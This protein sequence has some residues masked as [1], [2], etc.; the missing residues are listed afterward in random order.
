[1]GYRPSRTGRSYFNNPGG[2][3]QGLL[4]AIQS[5]GSVCAL[6]IAPNL[7][8][9]IG[10]KCSI[11]I[12]SLIVALGAGLQFGATDTG[13]FIAGRFFIG[14]GSGINGIASPLLI[15]ELAHPSQRGKITAVYNTFYYFRSTIAAWQVLSRCLRTCA[16]KCLQ[17][18]LW[19]SAN[20]QQ[21]VMEIAQPAASRAQRYTAL[22][23][24]VSS[25]KSKMAYRKG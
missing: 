11:M 23:T 19:N 14:L 21:L 13:M 3:Q 16:N 10:R 15:T 17:D 1:M 7:A 25:R 8:D 2:S 9:W 24:L 5:V 22:P 18:D 6:P 12:G 4:N 20:P